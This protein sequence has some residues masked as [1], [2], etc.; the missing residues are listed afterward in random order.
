MRVHRRPLEESQLLAHFEGAN[1]LDP[2]SHRKVGEHRDRR[3]AAVPPEYKA[4]MLNPCTCIPPCFAYPAETGPAPH[5]TAPLPARLPS[6]EQGLEELDRAPG[7]AEARLHRLS[8][9]LRHGRVQ[10]RQERGELLRGER[11]VAVGI[12]RRAEGLAEGKARARKRYDA[13]CA[14]REVR[15]WLWVLLQKHGEKRGT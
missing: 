14:S 3:D 9:L 15:E 7:P 5:C 8:R 4:G 11:A 10:A 2:V 12:R 6:C 1:I 13:G